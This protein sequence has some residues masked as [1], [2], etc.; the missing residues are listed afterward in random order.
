MTRYKI[1]SKQSED[2]CIYAGVPQ[3]V[4]NPHKVVCVRTSKICVFG[5]YKL[6]WVPIIFVV[7]ATSCFK[8]NDDGDGG[9]VGN[10]YDDNKGGNYDHNDNDKMIIIII[11]LLIDY[12]Q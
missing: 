10:D 8:D 12:Y 3:D 4:C 11:D 9:T 5:L 1:L 2:Q 6:K 7:N